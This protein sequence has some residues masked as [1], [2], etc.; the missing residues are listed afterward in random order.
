MIAAMLSPAET[1]RAARF[2]TDTLR[3]RWMAGRSA[4]RDVLGR[5]LGVAPAE[6]AIRRGVRGRPELADRTGLHRF[7]RVAHARRRHHRHRPRCPPHD[8]DRCRPRAR[9]ARSRRRSPGAKIPYATRTGDARRP[10]A[11]LAPAAVPALLDV[12]GGDEQG[13]RRRH[14]RS[15]RPAR[16]RSFESA[17]PRAGPPPYVP[18]D[19]SLHHPEVPAG[20]IATV[21]IWRRRNGLARR[22]ASTC[23]GALRPRGTSDLAIPPPSLQPQP[24]RRTLA[25]RGFEHPG[26]TLHDRRVVESRFR[27]ERR[28]RKRHEPHRIAAAADAPHRHV[29]HRRIEEPRDLLRADE[30]RRIVV[31]EARPVL[32]LGARGGV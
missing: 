1:S 22:L 4:L 21:A 9:R 10:P 28:H 11:R 20:W 27:I 7:Q 6:V 30:E 15:V 12:Q 2:G 19:W 17:T 5:T 13:H 8:A 25:D 16:R 3:H 31:Q 23:G 18:A 26:E 29:Q 14:H 32:L 24:V